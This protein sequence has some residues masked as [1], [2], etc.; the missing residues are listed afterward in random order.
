[1]GNRF[2]GL[3]GYHSLIKGH[4]IVAGITFL[5]IVP[6][7]VLIVKFMM[8]SRPV[9]AV[10]TH[11]WLQIMTVI[12]TTVIIILGFMAVGPDRALSN[13]HHGIGLAIY[14]LVLAQAF[15]GWFVHSRQKGKIRTTLTLKVMVSQDLP[16]LEIHTDQS[17]FIDGVAER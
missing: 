8:G 15:G 7:A 16:E 14:V 6:T 12:L 5:V 17:S 9:W 13:P 10:R 11:I 1:M 3:A 4:A 2:A